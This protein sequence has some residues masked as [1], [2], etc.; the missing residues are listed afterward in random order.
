MA[1]GNEKRAV[2]WEEALEVVQEIEEFLLPCVTRIAVVG[3]VRRKKPTVRDVELLC[4]PRSVDTT[5]VGEFFPRLTNTLEI[6]LEKLQKEGVVEKR[7]KSDG[8]FSYGK[9]TKLLVHCK[10]RIPIDIFVTDP[11]QWFNTLVAKTG[12]K[13]N[14]VAIAANAKRLGMRWV[15]SSP[16][17]LLSDGSILPVQKEEDAFSFVGLPYLL[18][19]QRP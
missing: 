2:P 8:T 16:G 12:G 7:I 3:S 6:G 19:H 9:K 17:F 14:N 11:S 5:P 15:T 13:E 18:P 10:S 4:I 1:S